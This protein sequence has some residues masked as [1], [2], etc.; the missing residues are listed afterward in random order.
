MTGGYYD[1]RKSRLEMQR[2]VSSTPL[3]STNDNVV[4]ALGM[5]AEREIARRGD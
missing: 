1:S 3:C 2:L 4:C 5:G